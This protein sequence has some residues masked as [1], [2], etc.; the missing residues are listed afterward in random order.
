LRTPTDASD[1]PSDLTGDFTAA[2]ADFVRATAFAPD[3]C[4]I[5]VEVLRLNFPEEEMADHFCPEG[6]YAAA[7]DSYIVMEGFVVAGT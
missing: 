1:S 2:L 4:D 7:S 5:H 6:I 3:L